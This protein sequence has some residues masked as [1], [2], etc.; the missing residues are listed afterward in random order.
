MVKS[1]EIRTDLNQI[2][3]ISLLDEW[4]EKFEKSTKMIENYKDN[5]GKIADFG[6]NAKTFKK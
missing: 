3:V 5:Y 2:A 4:K 6:Q 1:G